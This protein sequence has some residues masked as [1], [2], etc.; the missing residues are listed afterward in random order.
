VKRAEHSKKRRARTVRRKEERQAVKA[1]KPKGPVYERYARDVVS[2]KIPAC[3]WIIKSCERHLHDLAVSAT[4]N[5][6]K[7]WFDYEEADFVIEFIGLLPQS[8]GEWAGQLLVLQ[9]WQQFIVASIFGWKRADGTRRF[10]TVYIEVPRKNGK[11]TLLAAIALYLLVADGEPGAEIYSAAT[12]KDQA[13]IIFSEAERMVRQSPS[14]RKYI[15]SFR[16]NLHIPGTASKFQPLATDEDSLDGLN[17]HGAIIDELH[18]HKTR[19]VWDV[20]E[21][22]TGSRR[23]PLLIAITTAGNNQLG[24]CYEQHE[25]SV[26]VL[27]KSVEHDGYFAY[28]ATIDEEDLDKWMDPKVHRKANP[29]YGI[30]I[31]PD[32]LQNLVLKAKNTPTAKLSF[33]M[34]RLNVWS[35]TATPWMPMEE[36]NACGE[37][38]VAQ[39]EQELKGRRCYGGLDLGSTQDLT[40][41]CAVFP[42]ISE[43]EPWKALWKFWLPDH[44]LLERATHDGVPYH[45]WKDNG[46]LTTTQ[47]EITD[48]RQVRRDIVAFGNEYV[49]GEI[50]FDPWNATELA[51][52]LTDEDG[53]V[54]VQMRQTYLNMSEPMKKVMAQVQARQLEHGGNPIAKWNMA[55]MVAKA[56]H[57]DA[58]RPWKTNEKKKRTDGGVALIMGEARA[59]VGMKVPMHETEGLM[60]I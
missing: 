40:A 39:L 46:L 41:F 48:Y 6:P 22:G 51:T 24:I 57:E 32:D 55:N 3:Q 53:F 14:L 10:R 15:T 50:G 44:N 37:A 52:A 54:M 25:F 17:I 1:R 43:G 27:E 11:S 28:I 5:N 42:P 21:T 20:L 8:K 56:N 49:L 16:D 23:Q 26:K 12:K 36:W 59:F 7:I 60:I 45:I 38:T 58:I 29:N 19:G 9:P 33:L 31:K 4:Q 35:A 34:K 47:G 2:G 18:A 13:R 30:S